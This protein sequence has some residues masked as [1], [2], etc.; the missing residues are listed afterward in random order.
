MN[1]LR[2]FNQKRIIIGIC[3]LFSLYVVFNM[4]E[5]S[6]IPAGLLIGAGIIYLTWVL[7]QKHEMPKKLLYLIIAAFLIRFALGVFWDWALPEFG[8]DNPVNNAGYVMED[9]FNR[10]QAAWTL[11]QS[12]EPLLS[13]FSGFSHT[14]QYGGLIFISA[15]IYR[16]LGGTLHQPLML[17]AVFGAISAIGVMFVWLIAKK[18]FNLKTANLAAWFLMLYPEACLLGSSQMREAVTPTMAL[19]I[20][21]M[22][23]LIQKEFSWKKATSLIL[24]FII[25]FLISFPFGGV[26]FAVAGVMLAL[27]YFQQWVEGKNKWLVRFT[28]IFLFTGSLLAIWIYVGRTYGV[29]Y[30]QYLSLY[31]SGKLAFVLES[32]PKNLHSGILTVYGIFRPLLPAALTSLGNPV[33]QGIA[34]WRSVGW[35]LLLFLL[36][37]SS[38]KVIQEKKWLHIAGVLSIINWIWIVVASYRSGGDMWDNPRYRLFIAGIQV[39]LAAWFIAD[40]PKKRN[41]WTRRGIIITALTIVLYLLWYVNRIVFNFGWPIEN[42]W[43]HVLFSFGLSFIYLLIDYIICSKNKAMQ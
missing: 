41:P 28:S 19:A 16:F 34:I 33:W 1:I 3:I 13:A 39:L 30:Q 18:L 32:V 9:A 8:Y 11:A 31:G 10:D 20:I 25:S 15:S 6:R 21:F 5:W 42:I 35:T 38:I 29:W 4:Q 23:L 22:V 12:D 27:P 17:V 2:K 36:V 14:D 24:L 37:L 43:A 40:R 26:L 7:F